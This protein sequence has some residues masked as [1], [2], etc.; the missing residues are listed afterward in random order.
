MMYAVYACRSGNEE[1]RKW[2]LE[3]VEVFSDKLQDP[4]LGLWRHAWLERFNY[5]VPETETYWLRG[6]G[7]ALASIA[8]ILDH[9]GCDTSRRA[10]YVGIFE[11]TL[12]GLL[13]LQ[14]ENG[15]WDSIAN[16]P[17]YTF[18][19]TSGSLLVS[20]AIVR[21][22]RRGWLDRKY[23]PIAERILNAVNCRIIR[24]GEGNVTLP[25]ISGPTNAMPRW[26]YGFVG[27]EPNAMYGV[28][29]YLMTCTEMEIL[30]G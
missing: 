18:P 27:E 29:I 22:T 15:L 20:Y 7:W 19:E 23:L 30:R 6:N 9:V 21:G 17:G 24:D 8:E 25:G 10:R 16:I 2:G 26:V 13:P 14:Q 3:N 5:V 12:E 1:L 4:T 28:G 11:R